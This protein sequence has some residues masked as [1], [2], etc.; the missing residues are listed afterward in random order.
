M[1]FINKKYYQILNGLL[2]VGLGCFSYIFLINFLGDIKSDDFDLYSVRILLPVAFFFFVIGLSIIKINNYFLK[3]SSLFIMKK[4]KLFWHFLVVAILLFLFNYFLVVFVKILIGESSLF[5][6][7]P[8]GRVI[9]TVIWLVELLIVSLVLINNTFRNTLQLYKEKTDLQES[10]SKAQY[11]AL[12]NQLNPHF[13]FNSLNALIS[14]IEYDPK[15]AIEFTRNLSDVY[16]YILQCQDSKLVTLKSE[17]EFLDA[18]I[19]LHK[20]RLGDCISLNKDFSNELLERK[21]P[22]LTLQLLAENVIKHNIISIS[23]PMEIKIEYIT[24]EKVLK[25]TNILRPKKGVQPSGKGMYNLDSRYKLLCD[26]NISF[27]K[28][29]TFF[30]VKTPLLDE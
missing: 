22:P 13:L 15:N 14:E 11:I 10:S 24:E 7:K 4:K 12:Q 1:R 5:Y 6:M 19:F 26:K 21:L 23:K 29:E 18:Y 25:V 16:R 3:N 8:K 20:V 28:T 17:L 9:I 27:E 2:F 30:I